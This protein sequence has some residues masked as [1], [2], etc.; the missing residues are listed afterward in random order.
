MWQLI[1]SA[2]LSFAVL[3]I[4]F[5]VFGGLYI[6]GFGVIFILLLCGAGILFT[7][8]GSKKISKKGVK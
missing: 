8:F 4:L 5:A 1:G 6:S 3:L 2:L 7:G